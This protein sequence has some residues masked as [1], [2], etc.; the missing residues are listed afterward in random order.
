MCFRVNDDLQAWHMIINAVDVARKY[1]YAYLSTNIF[2]CGHVSMH[3]S[4]HVG[5]CVFV[6]SS[7]CGCECVQVSVTTTVTIAI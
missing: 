2:V 1:V 4:V 5:L 6:C 3:V 7:A